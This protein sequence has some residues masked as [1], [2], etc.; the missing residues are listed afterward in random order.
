MSMG[1]LKLG[2]RIVFVVHNHSSSIY[3]F[4]ISNGKRSKGAESSR[5]A[6]EDIL[7]V[8]IELPCFFSLV[9][10]EF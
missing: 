7:I 4:G 6:N 2:G 3:G 1:W 10:A 5:L 8:D 9:E